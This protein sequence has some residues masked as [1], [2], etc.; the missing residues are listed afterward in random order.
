MD[1]ESLIIASKPH[2]GLR[3]RPSEAKNLEEAY[4]DVRTSLAPPKSAENDEKPIRNRNFSEVK[5]FRVM[6][7]KL[8]FGVKN[9]KLQ[10]VRNACCRSFAPI[11]A[12]F[13]G[14]LAASAGFAKRKQFVP[15][16]AIEKRSSLKD[17]TSPS[18]EHL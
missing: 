15:T 3:T 11:R 14:F 4:F 9:Q 8:F 6:F 12:M 7:R 16:Y 1:H 13:A 2:T 10:I 17:R 18:R 5:N